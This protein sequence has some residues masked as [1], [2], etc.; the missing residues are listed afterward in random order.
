MTTSFPEIGRCYEK[1]R[2]EELRSGKKATAYQYWKAISGL[3]KRCHAKVV[4]DP[5]GRD[6][7]T[8]RAAAI[9]AYLER[10]RFHARPN[11]EDVG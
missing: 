5:K 10:M 1:V 6:P 4:K 11:D 7:A 9:E 2:R 3:R 8:E